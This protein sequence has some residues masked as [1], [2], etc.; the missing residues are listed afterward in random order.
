LFVLLRCCMRQIQAVCCVRWRWCDFFVRA[1]SPQGVATRA[2]ACVW[3]VWCVGS[4]YP[5][6]RAFFSRACIFC[7][8]LGLWTVF[9]TVSVSFDG[10]WSIFDDFR[11]FLVRICT[12]Q[13]DFTSEH[14]FAQTF[15]TPP[16]A[17]STKRFPQPTA[18]TMHQMHASLFLS[19]HVGFLT[20]HVPCCDCDS[21]HRD[22][23][24]GRALRRSRP[25]RL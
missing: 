14:R 3:L 22:H 19:S 15:L 23:L 2:G 16:S 10:F 12:P 18:T 24:W 17:W 21:M 6:I 20:S 7:E 1:R 4:V 13:L 9:L 8:R 25:R 11:V 5:W